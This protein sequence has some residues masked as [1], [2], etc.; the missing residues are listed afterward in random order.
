M[1]FVKAPSSHVVWL[2]EL[3]GYWWRGPVTHLAQTGT[4]YSPQH[5]WQCRRIQRHARRGPQRTSCWNPPSYRGKQRGTS[6]DQ[7]PTSSSRL[8]FFCLSLFSWFPLL[9]GRI[10]RVFCTTIPGKRLT[11]PCPTA[12][13]TVTRATSAFHS[14]PFGNVASFLAKMT[15]GDQTRRK[16]GKAPAL[17]ALILWTCV[18]HHPVL[19]SL[20]AAWPPRC[21]LKSSNVV[22]QQSAAHNGTCCRVSWERLGEQWCHCARHH[23]TAGAPLAVAHQATRA[24]EKVFHW[25]LI[26]KTPPWI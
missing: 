15:R 7:P 17:L 5:W 8:C 23:Y 9:L 1:R 4:L 10:H 16:V 3:P 12:T 24:A 13:P 21:P 25:A 6:W 18:T 22:G 20:Y 26:E 14:Q 11:A 2:P 19:S